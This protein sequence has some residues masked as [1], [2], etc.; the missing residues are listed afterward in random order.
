MFLRLAVALVEVGQ[1]RG[2]WQRRW[3]RSGQGQGPWNRV[4]PSQAQDLVV[5]GWRIDM[6]S[7]TLLKM[8]VDLSSNRHVMFPTDVP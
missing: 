7:S 6:P 1:G 5:V 4:P 2:P 3:S 8:L